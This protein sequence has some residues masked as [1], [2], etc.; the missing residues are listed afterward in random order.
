MLGAKFSIV[1]VRPVQSSP[2]D[3]PGFSQQELHLDACPAGVYR[4]LIYLTDVDDDNGPFEYLPSK[5]ATTPVQVKG[6]DG[7][8]FFF[9][10]NAV[11]HRATPPRRRPRMALD[12]IM[13]V[14]PESCTEIVFSHAGYTWPV[15]PY[16]FELD[17]NCYP[18]LKG[19]RW[20]YPDLIVPKDPSRGVKTLSAAEMAP[21]RRAG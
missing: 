7:A 17:A 16:L 21:A 2:H 5:E 13:L 10:A 14:Q 11:L 20:F 8:A 6:N 18:R 1:N 15:D 12:L 3:G 9:D 19:D 4:G